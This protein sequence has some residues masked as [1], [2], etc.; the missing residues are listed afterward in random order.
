[1]IQSLAKQ[2]EH[3][4]RSV[5]HPDRDLHCLLSL[6]MLVSLI[7]G[8]TIRIEALSSSKTGTAA[9]SARH[10]ETKVT[11][12]AKQNT[13]H[14]GYGEICATEQSASKDQA[15]QQRAAMQVPEP[16]SLFMMGVGLI[17]IA[18]LVRRRLVRR[19]SS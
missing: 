16:A 1:M 18:A 4:S 6:L 8:S 9:D 13:D 19:Q 3:P 7:V 17:S 12:S 11:V 14:Q 10:G 2:D 5:L 15:C